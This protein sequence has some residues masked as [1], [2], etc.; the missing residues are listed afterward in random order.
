MDLVKIQSSET[1]D[2]YS[3]GRTNN[4]DLEQ[5]KQKKY[6][7]LVSSSYLEKKYM[8]SWKSIANVIQLC[9]V[10]NNPPLELLLFILAY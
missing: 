9:P 2:V 7:F 10:T 4:K 5:N 6:A 1:T 3:T 8:L